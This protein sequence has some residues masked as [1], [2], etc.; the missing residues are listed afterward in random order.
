[1][2]ARPRRSDY[3]IS[4]RLQSHR[5][6]HACAL[7]L[8]SHADVRVA[9]VADGSDPGSRHM[10]C[11]DSTG[12]ARCWLRPLAWL[13]AVIHLLNAL[14]HTLGDNLRPHRGVGNVC[15]CDAR[16]VSLAMS[17]ARFHMADGASATDCV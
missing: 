2:P 12:V 6:R 11:P 10:L 3:R 5:H 13:Y 9:R 8:V 17:R 15:P 4:C 14:G 16:I 7:E 1:R